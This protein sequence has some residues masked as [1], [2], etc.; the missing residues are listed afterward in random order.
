LPRSEPL[1]RRGSRRLWRVPLRIR[2]RWRS[3]PPLLRERLA[4]DCIENFGNALGI[5]LRR[6]AVGFVAYLVPDSLGRAFERLH[7]RE[8]LVEDDAA[9]KDVAAPVNLL[10]CILLR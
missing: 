2:G 5:D 7:A 4:E 9:G 8:Q 10:P 1:H 6:I 3:G